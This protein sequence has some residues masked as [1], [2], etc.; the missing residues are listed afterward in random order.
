MTY[1]E[2]LCQD[3]RRKGNY[4]KVML[5]TVD[6][7]TSFFKSAVW[8]FEGSRKVFS[9]MPLPAGNA[10]DPACY[11][12]DSAHWL[13]A[14]EDSCR[15]CGKAVPLADIEALVISG[16]G[17]TLVPVLETK[18]EAGRAERRSAAP[19]RL[20]LDRRAE[21]AAQQVSALMGEFVD[22]GFFLPKAL[23][24]KINEPELYEKTV[25]FLGCPELL[26]FALTGEART[27]FPTDGFE[28][29]Y[30]NDSIL[31]RLELDKEKFP[32]FIRPG[33]TFG[34]LGAEAAGRI[35]F[36]KG[37][38]VIAGGPDFFAAILGSGAVKP[39]QACDRCGTSE[40]INV[41]TKNRITDGRLMSYSH[42]QKPFWNLSGIISTA[43]KAIEWAR[44]LLGVKTFDDFFSLAE[45]AQAGAGGLVFL[46]YLAGERTPIWNPSAR[47]VL[48]GLSL[49]TGR[50]EFARSIMEGICFAV[51]D[52]ICV[53]EEAGAEVGELRVAGAASGNV[54]LNRIKADIT[55]KKTISFAQKEA[56]LLG[57]AIIGFCALGK[58]ASYS[59]AADVL[60]RTEETFFPN[61][62]NAALYDD[63]F[64]EYRKAR[65]GTDELFSPGVFPAADKS[66]E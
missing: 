62:K 54:L 17:P 60:V 44:D 47:A 2:D 12:M 49:S 37:V 50:S 9:A 63:L 43:G 7:G 6:I 46:P 11:E 52:V 42:P 20:W 55:K 65:V 24:I 30:W 27:V 3:I 14:F 31:E 34:G 26:A 39:G 58:Y 35:G 45:T 1:H 4:N 29:W 59:E 19:A 33:E 15:E 56:E 16:N 57:N 18:A 40:G 25:W 23:D 32:L 8:D 10:D 21:K 38:P 66:P 5:L 64:A 48:R 22:A 53:M 61:E 13:K 51:R 28:R 41:C 36:R